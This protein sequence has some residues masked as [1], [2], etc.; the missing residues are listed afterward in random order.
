MGALALWLPIGFTMGESQW[1]KGGREESEVGMLNSPVPSLWGCLGFAVPLSRRSPHLSRNPL[2]CRPLLLGC[3]PHGATGL[4]VLW[5]L[6]PNNVFFLLVSLHPGHMFVSCHL[7][8]IPNSFVFELV[9]VKPSGAM[10]HGLGQK[11]DVQA[12]CS[13]LL[14]ATFSGRF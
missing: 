14:G 1:E 13:L 11:R 9:F 10:E 8:E 4:T 7:P 5:L 6:A 3:W 12:A 2:Q